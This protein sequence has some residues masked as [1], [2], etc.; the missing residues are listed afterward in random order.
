MYRLSRAWD[1]LG[2]NRT[3][4]SLSIA[5]MGDG[6]ANSI[7]Y[8]MIPLYVVQLPEELLNLPRELLIGIL[9]S[10]YGFSNV[11]LQPVMATLSDRIGQ[12]KRI[13]Q[14]GLIFIGIA[15]LSFSFA[16]RYVD[17]LG[18]RIAQGIGLAMEIPP[19]LALLGI[20]T[21]KTTRGGSM[22]FYTTLRMTGLAIGPLIGGFLHDHFGF[23]AAFYAGATVILLALIVVEIGVEKVDAPEGARCAPVIDFSMVNRGILS[24]ALATF[25]IATA[26]TLVTTL[27]NEINARLGIRAFGFGVA[28]SALMVGRLLFQ[29][30]LGRLSD[31][32][33]RKPFVFWGL[34]LLAP[35]TALMS[36]MTAL[37]QFIAIRLVQGI[38]AAAIVAPAL[39]F[40]GDIA[41]QGDQRSRSRQ[42]SI[43]TMG[44]GLG[45]AFGPLMAG[46]LAI[47]FFQLPFWVDGALCLAGSGIV[48]MFMTETVQ[49]TE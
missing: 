28:F 46:F 13:I 6:I 5:R 20:M 43:I 25:L 44:F 17:I 18:L 49:R 37:W 3:I 35:A 36:E 31:K 47:F 22:G 30:P 33:G 41:E 40:A 2:L 29:V 39:A 38:A 8:V 11:L 48:Y 9:I 4:F 42:M 24:A 12:Y 45:I 23:N 14:I 21:Q 34:I 27:E 16:N 1:S 32:L 7:L 10:A 15:T 19:T 26:F